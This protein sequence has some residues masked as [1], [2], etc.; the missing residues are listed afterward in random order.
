MRDV[1]LKIYSKAR[2]RRYK[3]IIIA[4]TKFEYGIYNLVN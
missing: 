2:F 3:G 1:T 4:D